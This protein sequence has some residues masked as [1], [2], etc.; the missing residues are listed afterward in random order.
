MFNG[1]NRFIMIL[2]LAVCLPMA[3]HAETGSQVVAV[4]DGVNL[5]K[6]DLDQEIGI[7]MPMNQSFHG[8]LSDEKMK[9]IRAEAL[10]NLVDSELR[11]QDAHSKG[12]KIPPAV[13]DEELNKMSQKFKSK[14]DFVSAYKAS[15]FTEKSLLRIIERRLLAEKIR[16]AEVD[17][18]VSVTPEKVKNYYNTNVSRYSKP[19]EFRASHILIKVDPASTSEQRLA[20]RAR[21]EALLK[22]INNGERF[23]EV[24]SNESDDLSKIKGGDLGP[25]H[26]GQTVAEFEEALVKMKVGETSKVIETLYGYHVIRLT[27]RRPPRQVPFDEIQDKIRTDLVESE[28][29]QLLE[30]WMV[31]LYKKAKITY[32]G[33]K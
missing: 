19:E 32:P 2:L 14:D 28:K 22:R 18:K 12:I 21:A 6:A 17:G 10:K 11:A 24:A 9:K 8:K 30:S 5:S 26:L 4:V 15:G 1:S 7:I 16:L 20:L 3:V 31:G 13:I 33:D 25:F 23:E 27:D 29:K